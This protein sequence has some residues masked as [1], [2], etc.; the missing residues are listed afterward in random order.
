M[1]L[2]Y[3]DMIRVKEDKDAKT[4]CL[5]MKFC[6]PIERPISHGLVAELMK[7]RNEN[8]AQALEILADLA[9]RTLRIALVLY[10]SV[11]VS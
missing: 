2:I 1:D 7:L 5:V 11:P 9:D 4:Y 3:R 10:D 8:N 6:N